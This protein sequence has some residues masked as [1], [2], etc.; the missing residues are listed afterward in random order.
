MS[1]NAYEA[2]LKAKEQALLAELA[3][4]RATLADLARL[5]G[6]RAEQ[7]KSA[8]SSEKAKPKRPGR[9]ETKY[10]GL[11]VSDTIVEVLEASAV[12]LSTGQIWAA[13]QKEGVEPISEDSVKAITWALRKRVRNHMDVV[14][15]AHGKWDLRSRYTEAQLRRLAKSNTGRGNFSREDHVALTKAGIERRRAAGLQ[16]GGALKMTPE[17]AA[18]LE[19]MVRAG[20]SIASISRHL[21]LSVGTIRNHYT[22]DAILKL[23]SEGVAE[24][25]R[26]HVEPEPGGDEAGRLRVVK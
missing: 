20:D 25:E 5:T 6:R 9:D 22:R 15:V 12:P 13:L 14:R 17:V 26:E 1:D 16:V 18:E 7:P 11:T 21:Q 4:V 8:P 2:F 19:R 3:S 10:S 23:R 24:R